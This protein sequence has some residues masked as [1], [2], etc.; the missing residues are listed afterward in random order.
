MALL[1][2]LVSIITIMFANAMVI[3]IVLTVHAP[4]LN[5][6]A[7]VTMLTRAPDLRLLIRLQ[8]HGPRI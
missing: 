8:H 2:S 5:I 7:I 3:V 6:S 4:I 1:R